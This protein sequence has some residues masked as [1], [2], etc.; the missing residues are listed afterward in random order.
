MLATLRPS[1][2]TC[3]T[4]PSQEI[5]A[6]QNI[7]PH[8]CPFKNAELPWQ[9]FIWHSVICSR[10]THY[11]R[12]VIEIL[13][14]S[15]V[16]PWEANHSNFLMTFRKQCFL[17]DIQQPVDD[18]ICS[19][20]NIICNAVPSGTLFPLMALNKTLWMGQ[21]KDLHSLYIMRLLWQEFPLMTVFSS[22]TDSLHSLLLQN[23]C[24][25]YRLFAL[26]WHL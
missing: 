25:L 10:Y 14:C 9:G 11:I 15:L 2:Q 17:M 21:R 12:S 23:D 16:H 26:R 8:K 7:S 1:K 4:K 24:C 13:A 6:K 20:W 18:N 3:F 22:Q 5:F 19:G